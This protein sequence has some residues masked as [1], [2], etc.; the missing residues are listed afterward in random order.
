[1]KK[2]I[3]YILFVGVTTL[4]ISCSDYNR[5][6]GRVYAP[7]MVYSKAVDYYHDTLKIGKQGGHYNK[8]P[9]AGTVAREQSLPDHILEADTLL[10]DANVCN[11]SLTESDVEEG[12]RLYMIYCGVCHGTALDGNGPLYSS[13]K[14]AAMPANLKSGEKYLKM[15]EG[16]IYHG[17]V[18]GKNM[19]G[20]YA[21][22][23]DT[24]Q[25]WQVVAYIKKIQS[26]NGGSP[27]TMVATSGVPKDSVKV[28][29]KPATEEH[30]EVKEHK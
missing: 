17:I 20:S 19:M 23:L 27:F 6:P 5:K 9:V 2:S 13:G 3:L 29:A 25:R 18:Y 26:E 10:A 7:D 14:F 28:E 8:M 16:R 30:K 22:Q 24:K 15:S 11:L 4:V 12:A 1:M 21:S